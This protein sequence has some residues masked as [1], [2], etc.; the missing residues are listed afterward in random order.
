MILKLLFAAA[1]RLGPACSLALPWHFPEMN[2]R[3]LR[4]ILGD[5]AHC[6]RHAREDDRM[7][8]DAAR[9]A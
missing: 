1:G 5:F 2:R 4:D 3:Q 7:R 8:R 9:R 6:A